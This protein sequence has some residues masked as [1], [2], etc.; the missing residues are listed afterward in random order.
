MLGIESHVTV[1]DVAVGGRDMSPF[2]IGHGFL[3]RD[4]E[5][6]SEVNDQNETHKKEG[7]LFDEL[8]RGMRQRFSES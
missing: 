6:E 8:H 2:I 7:V 3:G 1:T 5:G 4:H